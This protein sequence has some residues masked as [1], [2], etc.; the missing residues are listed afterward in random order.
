MDA[1]WA[2]QRAPYEADTA[3]CSDVE[4][5]RLVL[6][7]Q[8]T[9]AAY[10]TWY[11]RQLEHDLAAADNTLEGQGRTV[12][13]GHLVVVG[14]VSRDLPYVGMTRGRE[15]EPDL[16]LAAEA[17]ADWAAEWDSADSAAYQARAEAGLE[18]GEPEAEI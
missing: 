2:A 11:D 3:G 18:P 17:E 9:E 5:D 16:D 8:Q 1:L 12:G 15:P 10:L 13:T 6:E 4:Y 14:D 7:R